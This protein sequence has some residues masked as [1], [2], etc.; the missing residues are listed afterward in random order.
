MFKK[1]SFEEEIYQAMEKTLVVNQVENNYGFNKLAQAAECLH[2][3]AEIF[4]QA[5][6]HDTATEVMDVLQQLSEAVK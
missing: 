3:A 1:A 5:G 6:M 2:N 4:D